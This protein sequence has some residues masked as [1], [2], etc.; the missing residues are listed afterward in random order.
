MQQLSVDPALLEIAENKTS[1]NYKACCFLYHCN[2]II[3]LRTT[4]YSSL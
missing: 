3:Y 1:I 4:H 2:S